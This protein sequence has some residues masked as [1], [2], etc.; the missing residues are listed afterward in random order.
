MTNAYTDARKCRAIFQWRWTSSTIDCHTTPSLAV[1]PRSQWIIWLRWMVIGSLRH[2]WFKLNFKKNKV[3]S[4]GA[5]VAKTTTCTNASNGPITKLVGH[6]Q[7]WRDLKWLNIWMKRRMRLIWTDSTCSSMCSIGCRLM[8]LTGDL[9]NELKNINKYYL[10]FKI[11]RHVSWFTANAHNDQCRP[12]VRRE[13]GKG[14]GR[15]CHVQQCP[16]ATTS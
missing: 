7:N 15:C 16:A 8:G 3:T 12:V 9:F 2:F 13:R 1:S 14:P 4:T 11:P 6:S 10:K 5:G